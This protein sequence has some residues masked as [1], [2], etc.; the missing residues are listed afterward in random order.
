MTYEDL[1]LQLATEDDRIVVL[2]AENRAAIRGLPE[3]LGERFVDVGICEQTMIGT[4]AGLA[5]RGRIPVVHAL[6]TFLTMRAFEFIR[7]DVGIGR[8]PVKLVGGVPGFL[9]D[10]NGPTHQ[11][12]E[13]IALM[14][15]IPGMRIFCPSDGE[16]LLS[17]LRAIVHDPHPCYVRY[18]ACPS[19][20]EHFEPFAFGRA[21]VFGD[22]KDV[23]LLVHGFLLA[24]AVAAA[25]L[26]R[27]FGIA[28]RVINVRTPV[29]IDRAT[30]LAAA[31]ECELLVTIEDHF[32]TG[33]LYSILAELF[34][35]ER[36]APRVLPIAM[37]HR[38]FRPGL[39]HDVL[40]FEGFTAS[41]IRD[42]V[43]ATL[44]NPDD[45]HPVVPDVIGAH[46]NN[47]NG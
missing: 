13:D 12:L 14:R 40:T 27:E 1:L 25:E 10:A 15:G 17:G 46:A 18:N 8:L 20:V 22:G 4:A 44:E 45:A 34:L 30:I 35:A 43:L 38:W 37:E 39:L 16:E 26:L 36:V 47:I 2:T 7:T 31:H 42:R 5:L 24:Q 19:M 9:S 23:A 33:G 11:A 3:K 21:E 6:A 41:A 32:V 29:P 28:A